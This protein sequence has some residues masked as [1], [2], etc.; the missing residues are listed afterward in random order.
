MRDFHSNACFLNVIRAIECRH[1]P[2]K[3]KRALFRVFLRQTVYKIMKYTIFVDSAVCNLISTS[4]MVKCILNILTCSMSSA[5]SSTM[6]RLLGFLTCSCLPY[7]V[8]WGCLFMHLRVIVHKPSNLQCGI[9]QCSLCTIV[10]TRVWL[11]A[12]FQLALLAHR[13]RT[14]SMRTLINRTP[15]PYPSTVQ[16]S[17]FW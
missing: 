8:I 1:V 16:L 2:I 5:T 11:N 17:V 14:C 3:S 6:S 12:N 13:F 9:C 4:L 10:R 15:D 7:M